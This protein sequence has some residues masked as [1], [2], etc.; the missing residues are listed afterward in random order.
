MVFGI[1]DGRAPK[2]PLDGFVVD[3]KMS[4]ELFRAEHL[5]EPVPD[6]PKWAP[7]AG[8]RTFADHDLEAA[9]RLIANKPHVILR[10]DPMFGR[11]GYAK[12]VIPD[13]AHGYL[14]LVIVFN[15]RPDRFLGWT[16]PHKPR[17]AERAY[18]PPGKVEFA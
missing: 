15:V 5:S 16:E 10:D 11:R 9:R 6:A 7:P 18:W 13:A 1:R 8:A 12:E 2:D 3:R 14:V 17:D 4:A